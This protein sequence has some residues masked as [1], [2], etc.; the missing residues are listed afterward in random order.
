MCQTIRFSLLSRF[1]SRWQQAKLSSSYGLLLHHI[2][3]TLPGGA[4]H[5]QAKYR[6]ISSLQHVLD[7]LQILLLVGHAWKT[8]E[9]SQFTPNESLSSLFLSAPHNEKWSGY[10]ACMNT[11]RVKDSNA[12]WCKQHEL[13]KMHLS[14]TWGLID[15]CRKMSKK[16]SVQLL[17]WLF[18]AWKLFSVRTNLQGPT[19]RLN[20]SWMTPTAQS[21]SSAWLRQSSLC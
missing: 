12:L 10:K 17:H 19:T 15:N 16:T 1:V 13:R 8:T 11:N 18:A 21:I 14:L 2:L 20:L 6:N 7:L 9:R 4:R 5:S 3:H